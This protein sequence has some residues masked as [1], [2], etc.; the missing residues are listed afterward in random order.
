MNSIFLYMQQGG[1][2]PPAV[3]VVQ[4]RAFFRFVFGRVWGRVNILL[5]ALGSWFAHV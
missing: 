2:P 4:E 3:A 5:A 1:G